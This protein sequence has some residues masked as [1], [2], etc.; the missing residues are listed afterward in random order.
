MLSATLPVTV[1]LAGTVR[2]PSASVDS[3]SASLPVTAELGAAVRMPSATVRP[4]E[5][6]LGVNVALGGR[7]E[8]PVP[9]AFRAEVRPARAEWAVGSAFSTW[10][11]A[12]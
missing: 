10:W 3:V 6:Q 9:R 7:V 1:S 8:S 5:A 12:T 2:R 11:E 4:V